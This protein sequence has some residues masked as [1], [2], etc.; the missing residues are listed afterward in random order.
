MKNMKKTAAVLAMLF[1]VSQP[2]VAR[3]DALSA[4]QGSRV[5]T[6][7]VDDQTG[8]PA[9]REALLTD[10]GI[11]AG[12]VAE[13]VLRE[14]EEETDPVAEARQAVVDYALQFVGNPYAY[15][16][17]SLTDGVDCSG[18]VQQVYAH[19]GYELSHSTYTQI[20]EGVGVSYEEAEPGDLILYW[21]HVALYM[22]DGKIVHA[23]DYGYGIVAGEEAT[24]CPII[25]VRRIIAG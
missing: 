5:T 25:A 1:L 8:A 12:P 13:A 22:G 11:L 14:I 10:E 9:K 19:F 24:Y 21:G 17:T 6:E 16:G 23:K 20:D 4:D 7:T 3:A 15:G 2:V 18:F